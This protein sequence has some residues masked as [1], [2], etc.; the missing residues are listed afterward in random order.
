MYDPGVVS[1]IFGGAKVAC[2]L[3]LI[4]WTFWDGYLKE[5]LEDFVDDMKETSKSM[6]ENSDAEETSET[7]ELLNNRRRNI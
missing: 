2:F 1:Y 6:Q 7:N 4:K 5:K 3:F